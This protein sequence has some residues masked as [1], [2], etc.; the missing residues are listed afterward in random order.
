MYQY[1]NAIIELLYKS[2]KKELIQNSNYELPK[3][4]QNV[5]FAIARL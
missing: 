5:H 4:A 2:I 1:Y 3:Q